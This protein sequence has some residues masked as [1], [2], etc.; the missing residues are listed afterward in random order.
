MGATPGIVPAQ[1]GNFD[2]PLTPV[3]VVDHKGQSKAPN[4]SCEKAPPK[5][6]E[7]CVNQKLD[8][9]RKLGRFH[10]GNQCHTFVKEVIKQCTSK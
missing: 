10:P 5:V 4:A 7:K 6:D 8:L 3:Q 9:D 2:W 1:G